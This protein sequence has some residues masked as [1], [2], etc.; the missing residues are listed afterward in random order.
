MR[1]TLR[2]LLAYMDD[3]LDPED[4][5]QLSAKIESSEFA[6]DLL[7]KT[8]DAMRRLRLAAPPVSD[9]AGI[10]ENVVAEYLDNT[11]PAE[12]VA[13][14]ERICLESD[15]HLAEVASCHEI[16]T[17]VLGEPAEIDQE[18]RMRMYALGGGTAEST[19]ATTPAEAP[20]AAE[21][22]AEIQSTA[23]R[24]QPAAPPV[25][26]APRVSPAAAV[27]PTTPPAHEIPDYLRPSFVERHKGKLVLAAVL[28][29]A[30]GG[31]WI[32]TRPS[33]DLPDTLANA[34]IDNMVAGVEIEVD[35]FT[36]DDSATSDVEAAAEDSEAPPFDPADAGGEA[37]PFA[38]TPVEEDNAPEFETSEG[39]QLPPAG[40]CVRRRE[41]WWG[42]RGA[43]GHDSR[44]S[45]I[46]CC[47][48][49]DRPTRRRADCRHAS[50]G[51]AGRTSRF[52]RPPVN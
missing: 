44:V 13:E 3:I 42:D 37:P 21:S 28:L 43:V 46:A 25:E 16:L 17:M 51:S 11:L 41:R 31:W 27:A 23:P 2:T 34:D 7:H 33:E 35:E 48:S 30:V 47:R 1:L 9:A 52:L 36:P 20:T 39:P 26:A 38:A 40:H 15:I 49:V 32:Y 29:V 12:E 45:R 22:P 8:R 10:D 14:F 50:A 24:E 6:R 5:E 19:P 18:A 4:R